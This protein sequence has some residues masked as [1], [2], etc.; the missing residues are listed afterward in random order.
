MADDTTVNAQIV[1]SVLQTTAS[2]LGS[3]PSQTTG[4]L[5]ALMTETLGMA[6]YNAVT[7][8][9]N[10]QMVTS[11]AVTAACSRILKVSGA[12]MIPPK[13]A[14]PMIVGISPNPVVPS[15]DTQVIEVVGLG[16]QD[17]MTVQIFDAN[18]KKIADLMGPRQIADIRP[19]SFSMITNVFSAEADY[20]FQVTN[21]DKAVSPQFP[22]A[23]IFPPPVVQNITQSS[24]GIPGTY[25]LSGSGF[26]QGLATEV[27]DE[28]FS[29][30]SSQVA[31]AVTGK[32]FDMKITP[33]AGGSAVFSV[34]VVNPDRR[35]SKPRMFAA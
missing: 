26:Q 12:P 11:A 27:A 20:L 15:P 30:V 1:D 16:F 10:S 6:M 21:P 31:S 14:K 29:P 33:P 34:V 2:V 8:Q 3:A 4:M 13:P 28:L 18:G 7:T 32:S 23:A 22:V 5:D 25:T 17:G 35:R 9:H 19:A 24:S